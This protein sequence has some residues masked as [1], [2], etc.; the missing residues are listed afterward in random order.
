M[1]VAAKTAQDFQKILE[2]GSSSFSQDNSYAKFDDS[3]N[4][5][6]HNGDDCEGIFPPIR[7]NQV[8]MSLY[9]QDYPSSSFQHQL[10]SYLSACEFTVREL[11]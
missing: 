8:I 9:L 3:T 10:Q 11:A 7:K 4:Y 5:L 2:E 6:P 1:L